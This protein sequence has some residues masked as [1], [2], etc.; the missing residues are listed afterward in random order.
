MGNYIE[1]VFVDIV[2]VK[3][4]K[5]SNFNSSWFNATSHRQRFLYFRS[6]EIFI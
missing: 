3:Y 6:F 2:K 5:F 4:E 1:I